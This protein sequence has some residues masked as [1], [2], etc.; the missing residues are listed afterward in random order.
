MQIDLKPIRSKGHISNPLESVTLY[1]KYHSV[2]LIIT[3]CVATWD[4]QIYVFVLKI[5]LNWF[6]IILY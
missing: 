6:K 4:S 3:F 1:Q 2:K 5:A